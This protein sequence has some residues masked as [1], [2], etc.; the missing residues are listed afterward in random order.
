M[1]FV[2]YDRLAYDICRF[3]LALNKRTHNNMDLLRSY[4]IV[5]RFRVQ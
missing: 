2:L 4:G 3:R 5:V 1:Y